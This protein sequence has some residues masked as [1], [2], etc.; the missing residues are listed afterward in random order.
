MTMKDDPRL[1]SLGFTEERFPVGVHVC[2]IFSDDEERQDSLMK[3]LLSGLQSGER[4]SC[5]SDKTTE[6]AIAELFRLHGISFDEIT[7]SGPFMLEGSRDIYLQD[8]RFD[9]ERMLGVMT[10]YYE[11]S[12]RQGYPA[13]RVI[14][15][16]PPEVQQVP[17][18]SRLLEY[19]SK[20][21]VLLRTHPVTAVCKYDAFYEN[22]S[23]CIFIIDV[24]LDRRFKYVSF[25]PA[26]ERAVGMTTDQ[27]MNRFVD[28]LFS[29]DIAETVSS[30]YQ[31]CVEKRTATHYEEVLDFPTGEKS[32]LTSLVPLED[33]DG[34][35]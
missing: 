20:V 4:T 11:D 6:H 34:R 27:V 17:D 33:L 29:R 25:N 12:V 13:A 26:E 18:G 16:M 22:I 21:S 7:A 14:G 32:F 28:D 15:E 2:Q 19:E 8:N 35:I 24:T 23:D 31:E 1:I 9:P 3:F 30:R 5:F 10:R